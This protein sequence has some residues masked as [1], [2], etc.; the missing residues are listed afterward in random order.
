MSA[1]RSLLAALVLLV[2]CGN[3]RRLPSILDPNISEQG[4]R[5]VLGVPDS[6]KRVLI[7]SQSSHLDINWKKTF[8]QYYAD[9]GHY[10]PSLDTL[11]DQGYLRAVPVDPITR[12]TQTWVLVFDEPSL[13]EAP[14]ETDMPEGSEPGVIDVRSGAPGAGTDGTPYS[15]W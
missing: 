3:D 7:L 11:V 10:P 4:L 8:D 9:R 1:I 5:D 12:S 14:A 2:A 15:E 6:A 13:E